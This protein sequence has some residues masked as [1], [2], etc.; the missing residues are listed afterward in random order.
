MAFELKAMID[1]DDDHQILSLKIDE[2]Q[3]AGSP[4]T[5]L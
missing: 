3:E 5:S 1:D 4:P 2:E